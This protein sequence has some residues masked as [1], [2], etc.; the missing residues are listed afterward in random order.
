MDPLFDLILSFLF[1]AVVSAAIVGAGLIAIFIL[2]LQTWN[3]VGFTSRSLKAHETILLIVVML[4]LVAAF[5]CN[6]VVVWFKLGNVHLTHD[7]IALRIA[8]LVFFSIVHLS[9]L[10]AGFFA[11]NRFLDKNV[12][13]N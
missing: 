12:K 2:A 7:N 3:P 10:F 11:A 13:T 6:P 4:F 1:L 5:V 8:V 9:I